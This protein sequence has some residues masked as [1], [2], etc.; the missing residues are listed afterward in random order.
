M[1][2][3][4]ITLVAGFFWACYLFETAAAAIFSLLS[5][6]CITGFGGG[7]KILFFAFFSKIGVDFIICGD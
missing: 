5:Y 4:K 7:I 1:G 2:I 3:L 6:S